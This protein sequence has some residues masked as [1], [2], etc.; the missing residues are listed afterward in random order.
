VDLS[1]VTN[2]S[3]W[4]CLVKE[5]STEYAIIRAYRSLGQVDT[6]AANTLRLAYTSGVKDLGVY[7]FPCI[8]S[9][10]SSLE[11][12]L[13]K[14]KFIFSKLDSIRSNRLIIISLF[15]II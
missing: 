4:D 3:I 6:N 9:S 13:F 12:C 11:P 8:T 10:N 14:T 1:I 7:M 15:L 2:S 5:H